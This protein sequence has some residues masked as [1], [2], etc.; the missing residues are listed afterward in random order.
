[1]HSS[2]PDMCRAQLVYAAED[3]DW[4]LAVGNACLWLSIEGLELL[5]GAITL[6]LPMSCGA[7]EFWKVFDLIISLDKC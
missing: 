1:M 2:Q 6:L 7:P 4:G 3:L 5:D